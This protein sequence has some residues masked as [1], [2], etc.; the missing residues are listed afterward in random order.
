MTQSEADNKIYILELGLTV[1]MWSPA[2]GARQNAKL[3]SPGCDLGVPNLLPR[4]LDGLAPSESV[5]QLFLWELESSKQAS[6]SLDHV[7][8]RVFFF[9]FWGGGACSCLIGGCKAD[10]GF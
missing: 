4:R 9:F 2:R 7:F 1:I 5:M 8:R 3:G 10:Q 6:L